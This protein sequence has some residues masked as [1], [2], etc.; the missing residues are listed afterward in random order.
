[1]YD[2]PHAEER[3]ARIEAQQQGDARPG[4]IP[5]RHYLTLSYSG[6][7]TEARAGMLVVFDPTGRDLDDCLVVGRVMEVDR[8][9]EGD[10]ATV[11]ANDSGHA[12][13]VRTIRAVL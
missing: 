7:L 6:G 8:D 2:D 9:E 11:A 10:Y 3:R 4:P 12:V 5:D 13:A 1:M